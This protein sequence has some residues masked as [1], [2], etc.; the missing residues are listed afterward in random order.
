MTAFE[1]DRVVGQ[2]VE[3]LQR[4]G[5]MATLED[6][7]GQ[8]SR[9]GAIRLPPDALD[10]VVRMTIRANRDGRGLGCFSQPD[11]RSVGLTGPR[12]PK[13]TAFDRV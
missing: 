13:P 4:L 12:R 7:K 5:G 9:S 6:L 3:A 2:I 1:E 10:L 11:P 8:I